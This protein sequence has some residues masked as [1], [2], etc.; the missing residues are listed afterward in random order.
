MTVDSMGY[1]HYY[2]DL[3]SNKKYSKMCK[4]LLTTLILCHLVKGW[5]TF[6][7]ANLTYLMNSLIIKR[8]ICT[9]YD[10]FTVLPHTATWLT[11]NPQIPKSYINTP[12]TQ[13]LLSHRGFFFC[14]MFHLK[15]CG[16]YYCLSIKTSAVISPYNRNTP[17]TCLFTAFS[18]IQKNESPP[19]KWYVSLPFVL[20]KCKPPAYK[21][22]LQ[23][24]KITSG[25]CGAAFG[26]LRR[27]PKVPNCVTG[28]A[29]NQLKD[30]NKH[31]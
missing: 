14:F 30:M 16:V 18:W 2:K 26:V 10:M 7:E 24:Y 17:Q 23:V 1:C 31:I 8:L 9:W 20:T 3:S 5:Y 21:C 27:H 28:M 13:E 22:K 6:A 4:G 19:V 12:N 29:A 11:S 25:V 15:E